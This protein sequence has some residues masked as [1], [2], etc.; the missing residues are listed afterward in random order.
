MNEQKQLS[1]SNQ[2]IRVPR[3]RVFKSR[4]DVCLECEVTVLSMLNSKKC[5]CKKYWYSK[6]KSLDSIPGPPECKSVALPI[7]LSVLWFRWNVAQVFST[8]SSSSS[9]RTQAD[10]HIDLRWQ[11]WRRKMMGFWR[12]EVNMV[13]LTVASKLS[14]WQTDRRTGFQ[15]YIYR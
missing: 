9:C 5:V 12:Q 7:E 1:I 10:C 11:T 8:S 14:V 6:K 4:F 3:W 2:H 15:L 13:M